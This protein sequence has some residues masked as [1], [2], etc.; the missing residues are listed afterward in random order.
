MLIIHLLPLN[1]KCTLLPC[2]MKMDLSLLNTFPL[3]DGTFS[4]LACKWCKTDTEWEKGFCFLV[5]V[6]LPLVAC[7][8]VWCLSPALSVYSLE[9]SSYSVGV[10]P[11]CPLL[12]HGQLHQAQALI[13]SPVLLQPHPLPQVFLLRRAYKERPGTSQGK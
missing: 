9:L 5:L 13:L 8:A 1:S 11:N 2:P 4:R 6:C 3:S 12:Q 10:C 7:A